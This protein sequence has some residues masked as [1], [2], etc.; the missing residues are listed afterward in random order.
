MLSITKRASIALGESKGEP[1]LYPE[2]KR[3]SMYNLSPFY[4]NFIMLTSFI[5]P[6]GKKKRTCILRYVVHVDLAAYSQ[7]ASL[8]SEPIYRFQA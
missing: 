2:R 6:S 7:Q 8:F 5:K 3:S 4:A 1:V